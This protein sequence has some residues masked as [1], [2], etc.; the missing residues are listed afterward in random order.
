M[1]VYANSKESAF[2]IYYHCL[3]LTL[4]MILLLNFVIAILSSTF[5]SYED[6]GLGLYYE[7]VIK[8]FA[9]LKYDDQYGYIACG[10]PPSN[11]IVFVMFWV[12]V[13]F[14]NGSSPEL[15]KKFNEVVCIMI[16]L[17]YGLI[18][19]MIFTFLGIIIT[20]IA[21]I[22]QILR[23]IGSLMFVTSWKHL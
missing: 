20:P 6:K 23:I 15:R 9:N 13:S 5:A 19:T 8:K 10:A 2:G 11:I 12:Q 3:F 21:Y 4:N 1:D 7:A 16:Y 18:M 22:Y 17:P 14:F